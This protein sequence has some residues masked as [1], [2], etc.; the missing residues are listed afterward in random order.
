M[1]KLIIVAL[2]FL[3]ACSPQSNGFWD[4]SYTNEVAVL[5]DDICI[6]DGVPVVYGVSTES[7]GNVALVYLRNDG[8]VVVKHYPLVLVDWTEGGEFYWTGG[9]CE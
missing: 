6:R 8:A 1:R 9:T 4:S 2:M 5:P 7:D 3:A